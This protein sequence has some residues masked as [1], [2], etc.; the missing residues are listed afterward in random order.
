[1][2]K[3]YPKA[4][5]KIFR[6][7]GML[8]TEKGLFS[9]R[10]DDLTQRWER[11]KKGVIWIECDGGVCYTLC[12]PTGNGYFKYFILPDVMSVR[13]VEMVK[14]VRLES[15]NVIQGRPMDQILH[16]MGAEVKVDGNFCIYVFTR[17]K[18]KSIN[19]FELMNEKERSR[20]L[21]VGLP[22]VLV[23]EKGVVQGY[24]Q[25]GN[26]LVMENTDHRVRYTVMPVE[27]G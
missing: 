7:E 16:Q 21:T 3:F 2:V 23:D 18:A 20:A 17:D 5:K 13:M 8:A 15:D 27:M 14:M 24:Y 12:F 26:G 11:F 4:G 22:I 1:V 6:G 25:S 9:K 10:T 19:P